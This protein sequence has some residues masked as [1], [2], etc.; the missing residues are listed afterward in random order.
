MS[1]QNAARL[2]LVGAV[3]VTIL[4]VVGFVVDLLNV[5]RGLIPA[6]RVVTSFIY[7]FAGVGAVVF[8]YVFHKARS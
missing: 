8:L 5:L 7:A 3:L 4:L 6:L 1:L 2:A